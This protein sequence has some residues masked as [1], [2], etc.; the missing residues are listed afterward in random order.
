MRTTLGRYWATGLVFF[1]ATVMVAVAVSLLAN[2][3]YQAMALIQLMPR[4]GQEVAV[5]EVVRSDVGGYLEVQQRARTQIQ[6]ILSRTVLG[7]VLEEYAARGYDD[8][9]PSPAGARALARSMSV[10]PRE[11]TQLVEIVVEHV[12]PERAALLANLVAD[13]Y[14]AFNLDART[15]AARDSKGWIDTRIQAARAELEAASAA[16]LAFQRKHDLVEVDQRDHTDARLAALQ[17]VLGEVTAE[18]VV[19]RSTLYRHLRL[20]EDGE[21]LVLAGMYLDDTTVNTI[22]RER[23]AIGVESAEV[24]ARYGEQH[25]EHQRAVGRMA[26]VDALLEEALRSR[27]DGVRSRLRTL[28][29]REQEIAAALK[30]VKAEILEQQRLQRQYKEL[31]LDEQRARDLYDS[32]KERETEIDLQAH[33]ELNDVRIVDRAV[34][35]T[36][37][38]SPNLPLNLAVAFVVGLLGG[39]G[40][41]VAR[42]RLAAA[43]APSAGPPRLLRTSVDGSGPPDAQDAQDAH[44]DGEGEAAGR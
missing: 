25:P 8:I 33:S 22:L 21:Y 30:E 41:M 20:L 12:N 4:A 32:L 1:L 24:L 40:L 29:L 14:S 7:R 37:P 43:A 38:A 35:P 42:W 31:E 27:I 2:P 36:R 17:E 6:I 19:L 26:Q 9:P 10:Q 11:N 15:D 3:R 39:F 34:T 13:V 28:S 5:E 18:R 44:Q 16:T 23:A